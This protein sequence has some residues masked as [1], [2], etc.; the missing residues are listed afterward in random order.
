MCWWES[1]FSDPLSILLKLAKNQ[2]VNVDG[3]P[4]MLSQTM[5]SKIKMK[6]NG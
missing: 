5:G 6:E 1:G 4:G 2:E 3:V